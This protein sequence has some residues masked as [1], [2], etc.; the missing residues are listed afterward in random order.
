MVKISPLFRCPP[1]LRPRLTS[2]TESTAVYAAI[3]PL[4]LALLARREGSQL[5]GRLGLLM[6]HREDI[7]TRCHHHYCHHHHHHHHHC[8]PGFRE[9]WS[10]PVIEFLTETFDSGVTREELLRGGVS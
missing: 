9:K 2:D 6:D 5:A 4:R 7:E 8:R 1:H 10:E 3:I